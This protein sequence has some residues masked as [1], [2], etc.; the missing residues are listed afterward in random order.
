MILDISDVG[1]SPLGYNAL[2]T[3]CIALAQACN[4]TL[5]LQYNHRR[6]VTRQGLSLKLVAF[7]VNG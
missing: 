4:I 5:S 1:R 6:M 7:V 2:F 3:M